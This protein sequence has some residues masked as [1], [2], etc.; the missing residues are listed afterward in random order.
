MHIARISITGMSRLAAER[1]CRASGK[2]FLLNSDWSVFSFPLQRSSV[3]IHSWMS[4]PENGV[5]QTDFMRFSLSL[6]LRN[7]SAHPR[8]R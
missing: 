2:E 4:T 5:L 8:I 3:Q 7:D 6:A 1:T